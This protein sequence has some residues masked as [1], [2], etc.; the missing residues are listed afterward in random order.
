MKKIIILGI[1]A[2]AIASLGACTRIETG[3]VGIE[4]SFTGDVSPDAV[5][6]GLH[7]TVLSSYMPIDTTQTRA[8][9]DGMQ[10][11]A[12]NGVTLRDVGVVVTYSLDPSRVAAF[13]RKTKEVDRE[14]G[15][16]DLDTVGLGILTRSVVPQAVQFATEQSN[17]Q[18]IA[19][20]QFEYAQ[21]IQKNVNDIL[22]RQYPGIN[23]FIIQSV[24]VP[25]FRLPTSIQ[26]Q[27]DAQAGYK[28]EMTT[29]AIKMKLIETRKA[30]LAAEAS[31]DANALAQASKD[32]G[33]PPAE[34]IAW[35][36]AQA[37]TTLANS[38]TQ[39]AV[40]LNLR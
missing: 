35:K 36:R 26:K 21:T 8:E 6:Q 13:Y 10:P 30:V 16:P 19:A 17:L 25:R 37:L 29:L 1:A 3:S 28:A 18:D 7:L 39:S 5:G 22:N 34:I 33:L 9:V 4:T 38:K 23:P 15:S 31:V 32:T 11:K 14:P 24:T 27:M 40:L 2:F 12:A 20:N